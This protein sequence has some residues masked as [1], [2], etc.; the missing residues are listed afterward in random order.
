[1][2]L[3]MLKME[4]ILKFKMAAQ[5]GFEKN[6]TNSD[7]VAEGIKIPKIIGSTN[8]AKIAPTSHFST[9]HHVLTISCYQMTLV[10]FLVYIPASVFQL[11]IVIS[12][13]HT[14]EHFH[15][16]SAMQS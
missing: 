16:A 15:A 9:N 10:L 6:G 7:I 1:M 8:V 14:L 4:A 5:D 11:F 12:F 13:F 2:S 3:R